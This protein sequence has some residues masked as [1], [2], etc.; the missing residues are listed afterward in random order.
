MY[1]SVCIQIRIHTAAHFLIDVNMC[2]LQVRDARLNFRYNLGNAEEMVSLSHVNVSDGQWHTARVERVGRWATL[3]LDSGVGRYY[4]HTV[5]AGH[6][7]IR[8]SQRSLIA[9]GNVR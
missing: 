2:L 5:G 8:V 4:N 7:E 1:I 6:L 9:G 3:T